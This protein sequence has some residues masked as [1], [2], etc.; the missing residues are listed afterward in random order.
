MA[1]AGFVFDVIP[2]QAEESGDMRTGLSGLVERNALAKARWVAARHAGAIVI[3]ADTLVAIDGEALGK[4]AD[5][6]HAGRMLRQLSGRTHEVC[7]GVALCCAA[8]GCEATFHDVTRV[9][10]RPLADAQIAAYF[11]CVN[12]LDKA[13][14]Y[15]AQER[16]EMIIE[17]MEGSWSNVVGLPMEALGVQLGQFHRLTEERAG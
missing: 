16:G 15:G 5:L 9:T 7:T 10:F 11:D 14:A 6:E 1:E 13:G 4:P 12:P 17:R 2:S 8:C 3:G